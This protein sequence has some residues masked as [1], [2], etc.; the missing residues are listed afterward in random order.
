ME[1]ESDFVKNKIVEFEIEGRKFKYKAATSR[2]ESEWINEYIEIID[3]KAV[4]DLQKLTKCKIRNLIEV[5]YSKELIL[6]II[7]KD[8]EW[9][10]LN[11]EERWE[12]LGEMSPQIF[13]KI[14]MKI[15]EIDGSSEVKK[16]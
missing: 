11:K 2:D 15:N 7:G 9:K 1:F 14:I 3:G 4:Q 6:S 12:L 10:D 16:N 8:K 5:P 13:N